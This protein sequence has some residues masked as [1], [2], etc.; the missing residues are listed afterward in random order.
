MHERKG[1]DALDSVGFMP[2]INLPGQVADRRSIT[3]ACDGP[4]R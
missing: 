2:C 4:G 1:Y 3:S